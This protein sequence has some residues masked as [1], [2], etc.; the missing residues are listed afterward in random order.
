MLHDQHCHTSFSLDSKASIEEYYKIALKNKTKYFITTEH[1]EFDSVYNKIDW[2]VD[3][4]ELKYTLNY[5][6]DK[7]K[8]ITPLLGVE[9]GYRKDHLQDQNLRFLQ[10]LTY[11]LNGLFD[12]LALHQEVE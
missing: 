4:E 5:L 8:T 3:Y 11:L 12:S 1:I 6:K 9:L 2:T 7:Y 10:D